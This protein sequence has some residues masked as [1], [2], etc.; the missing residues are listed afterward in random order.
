[1]L[2]SMCCEVQAWLGSCLVETQVILELF[3]NWLVD[4]QDGG[5]RVLK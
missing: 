5:T 1:M 3:V 2:S 4:A